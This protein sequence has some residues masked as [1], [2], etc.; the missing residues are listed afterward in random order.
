MPF[1]PT[2]RFVLTGVT[3]AFHHKCERHN[4]DRWILFLELIPQTEFPLYFSQFVEIWQNH[5]S[6]LDANRPENPHHQIT[7]RRR[8]S[9]EKEVTYA[10]EA[11]IRARA[12]EEI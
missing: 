6:E 11:L 3:P 9:V 1:N 10:L 12:I 8:T 7:V 5:R 2:D 4:V